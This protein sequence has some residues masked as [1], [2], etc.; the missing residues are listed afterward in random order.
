MK[1]KKVSKHLHCTLIMIV[2]FFLCLFSA[3]FALGNKP[4][5]AEGNAERQTIH[6]GDVLVAEDYLL[7]VDGK[8]VN[9]E[10]LTV[11]YP[12]GSVFGGEKFIIEQAGVYEVTY[13]ATANE[14]LVEEKV[15]YIALR[16]PNNMV[17]ADEGVPVSYGKYEV[18]GNPYRMKKQTYG[19]IVGLRAGEKITFAANIKTEKLTEGYNIL[20]L[21]IMPSLF[22]ETDFERLVIR[23][24]D[25]DNPD[26]FVEVIVEVYN[27]IDGGGQVSYVKAGANGQQ[28]GGWDGSTFRT[29]NYGREVEV[30]FRGLGYNPVVPPKGN[31][32]PRAYPE[33]HTISEH[34]LTLSLDHKEKKIFCGPAS[35]ENTSQVLVNDLDDAAHYKGNPWGG[36]TSDEITVSISAARF[37]KAEGK[38]LIKSYGDYDFSKDIVDTQA[39][40]ISVNYDTTQKMPVAIVGEEFPIFSY[41]AKDNLDAN[42]NC[43]VWVYYKDANGNKLTVETDGK[44]FLAKYAGTY[45]IVYRAEDYS[46]N[47]TVISREITAVE[48]QPTIFLSIPVEEE[49]VQQ[50]VYE[51]VSVALATEVPAFGGSGGITVE[52]TVYAPDGKILNVKNAL[53]LT[54]LGDYKVVYTATDYLG[55]VAHGV[56]TIRAIDVEKPKFVDEPAFDDKLIAG[57]V[58]EFPQVFV[59]ETA[60]GEVAEVFCK[61]YVNDVEVQGSF[62]ASGEEMTIRYVAEGEKGTS[63]W[64]KTISVVDTEYGKYISKYFYTQDS[65]A[66]IDNKEYLEL[67]AEADGKIGFINALKSNGFETTMKFKAESTNFSAMLITLTDAANRKLSVTARLVYNSADNGWLLQANGS[68]KKVPFATSKDILT[69][70]L[71]DGEKIVDA[72]NQPVATILYYDNG[73]PFVGFSDT[74]YLHIAFEGVKASSS[75][76]LTQICNQSMGHGKKDISNAEDEIRPMIT[77]DEEFQL[78]QKLGDKANIPTAKA[79]DVLSQINKFTVKVEWN[80]ELIAEGPATEKLDFTLEKTG[81]YSV[82]YMARDTNGNKEEIPFTIFVKDETA[83]TLTVKDSLKDSYK[84]GDKI[85]IPTYSAKDNGENCYVQ[86]TLILPN[87][88]MRLLQYN[89]N[90]EITSLLDKDNDLYESA[91][92]AGTNTFVALQKGRYVLRI[93]AYDEYY[94]YTVKEIEFFV[95]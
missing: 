31:E 8:T 60:Y 23:L 24:A 14:G 37:A 71:A 63:E 91:F 54:M 68:I 53:Q 86:V 94:N 81:Y 49:F 64:S 11:V 5:M 75:I 87:N 62:T 28:A 1:T 80:G 57:F 13:Y 34:S 32:D 73:E 89:E 3:L 61:T 33:N 27:A 51:T 45:E 39:P 20:D 35:F 72:S 26:N 56:K 10:G 19:A 7:S 84:V 50:E 21:L 25:A 58:Y 12:N 4:A 22:K 66:A 52:R 43:D 74:I 90:G 36:F 40:Q 92:K 88:E 46:G 67:K 15:S 69:F 55:N 85:K 79:Y 29:G 93:V 77:F 48:K 38:I 76:Y 6:V 18:N 83:P 44:T 78:R 70:K 59:I 2:A 42:L 41:M 65:I 95:K 17:V 30:S 9:A 47:E 16:S 82:T